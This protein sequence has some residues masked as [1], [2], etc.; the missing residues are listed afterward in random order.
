MNIKGNIKYIAVSSILFLLVYMFLAAIPMGSDIY[1]DPVWTTN[2]ETDTEADPAQ[3]AKPG[4]EAFVLGDRFGYFTDDGTVL[5]SKHIQDRVSASP[6]AWTIYGQKAT[7]TAVFFPDGTQKLT[8]SGSGFVHL[9]EDRTYQFLPGGDAVCQYADDGSIIWKREHTA[10]ITT[11][12]SSGSAT[13]IGY[14]DGLLTCLK[15]DGSEN[16]SFYPGGSDYQV[17]LGASV[18]E[19]GSLAAC[20][21]G[22]EKQRF[23]L[24]RITGTQYKVIYHAYLEGNLRR[25][26]FVSFEDSGKFAFFESENKLG[27]IDCQKL[28]ASSIPIQ[29]RIISAGQTPGDSLFMFLVK[30]GTKYTLEALEKH[31]HLVASSSFT[32]DNAFLVQRREKIFIGT[33]TNISRIDIKGIK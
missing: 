15:K 30:N 5:F 1:F 27:I 6:S 8:V 19:D 9:D 13:I 22:I 17:I 12:K 7:D 29:G 20:V 23:L 33:D 10:P 14:A 2:I 16:F 31:T 3:L 4:I 18:S 26:T 24:I 25:Q 32:A 11:F 21:S 28:T